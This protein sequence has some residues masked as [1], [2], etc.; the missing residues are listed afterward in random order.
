M[1]PAA[2]TSRAKERDLE[3]KASKHASKREVKI[4][5]RVIYE[6]DGV[7]YKGEVVCVSGFFFPLV[8]MVRAAQASPEQ[9]DSQKYWARARAG[10]PFFVRVG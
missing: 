10:R 9:P 5:D 4:M 8:K 2:Q 7:N 3:A 1:S 6:C